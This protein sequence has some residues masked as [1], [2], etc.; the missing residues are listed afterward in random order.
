M[1]QRQDRAAL[2]A[3]FRVLQRADQDLERDP[4]NCLPLWHYS[5]P[6]EFKERR[7]DYRRFGVGERFHYEPIAREEYDEIVGSVER[8][9][10][11]DYMEAK[12]FE[13]LALPVRG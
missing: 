2:D 1:D 8:W 7:W 10:L 12:A 11:D 3:F 6:P 9:G 4:A 5:V 13:E